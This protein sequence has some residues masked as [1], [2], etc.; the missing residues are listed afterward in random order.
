MPELPDHRPSGAFDDPLARGVTLTF[1][2]T[3]TQVAV[4][5]DLGLS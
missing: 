5:V 3:S 1:R 4:Q 2:G